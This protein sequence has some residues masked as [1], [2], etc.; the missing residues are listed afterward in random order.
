MAGQEVLDAQ[1]VDRVAD[2][3][4]EQHEASEA[5]ALGVA[6]DLGQPERQADA[7]AP[8]PASSGPKSSRPV[9]S[10]AAASTASDRQLDR[11]ALAV[12]EGQA[13]DVGQRGAGA[14]R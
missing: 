4:P 12:L 8:P 2:A 6:V 5:G 13:L 1:P 3:V 14:G 7:E 9:R 11:V 10:A